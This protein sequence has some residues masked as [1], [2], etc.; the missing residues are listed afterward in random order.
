[1]SRKIDPRLR[2]APRPAMSEEEAEKFRSAAMALMRC[3]AF[4][5]LRLRVLL[6]TTL[7]AG[8]HAADL[9]RDEELCRQ[10]P[11]MLADMTALKRFIKLPPE[12]RARLLPQY[13]KTAEIADRRRARRDGGGGSA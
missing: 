4:D 10:G 13:E 1:M 9:R 8:G 11:D 6:V 12:T 5:D 2:R 7:A 3:D